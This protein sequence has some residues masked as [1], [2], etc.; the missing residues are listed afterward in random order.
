MP[1]ESINDLPEGVKD[2]L[3]KHA[4]EIFKEAFNKAWD[5]YK[6]PNDRK[7]NV[8]REETAFKV[9]WAAVKQA[10]HKNKAGHWIPNTD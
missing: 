2:N 7:D 1:Y 4:K 3:P 10:Y 9:S 6:E 5:E 8:S